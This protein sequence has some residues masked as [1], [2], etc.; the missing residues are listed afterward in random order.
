VEFRIGGRDPVTGLYYVIYPDGSETLHGL[1]IFNAA[2]QVG[3]VVRATL[4]S[5]GMMM[6][7]GV[8]AEP[9]PTVPVAQSP[10]PGGDFVARSYLNGRVFNDEEPEQGD[11]LVVKHAPT[12]QGPQFVVL[13]S[14]YGSNQRRTKADY[15]LVLGNNSG[16][17][18]D[19]VLLDQKPDVIQQIQVNTPHHS[20]INRAVG[21]D[22][23]TGQFYYNISYRQININLAR[24]ICAENSC[25]YL[26][27][28]T[29]L[30]FFVPK[31]SPSNLSYGT[32]SAQIGKY[33]PVPATGVQL[34]FDLAE[35]NYPYTLG[36]ARQLGWV[37]YQWYFRHKSFGIDNITGQVVESEARFLGYCLQID[38]LNPADITFLPI[39]YDTLSLV[40]PEEMIAEQP[41]LGVHY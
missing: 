8:K 26:L 2:H 30:P 11:V 37:D 6:L 22:P 9:T 14:F 38:T 34:P 1:K 25:R 24:K 19:I 15:L 13:A 17:N 31:D 5:D 12:V 18:S 36:S 23:A 33:L 35:Y 39:T 3:D 32:I 21:F 40:P 16:V 7:D 29:G 28:A 10:L 20:A 27:C 41:F 4:R